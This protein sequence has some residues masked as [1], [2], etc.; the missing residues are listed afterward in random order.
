MKRR[1]ISLILALAMIILT[2]AGCAGGKTESTTPPES[3]APESVAPE[4]TT[5]PEAAKIDYPTQGITL[6]VPSKAGGAIDMVS[7]T[8]ATEMEKTLGQT[9]TV[10]NKEGGAA[11]A[12]AEYYATAKN[13]GYNLFI[14]DKGML[15]NHVAGTFT[16]SY[17]DFDPIAQVDESVQLI[18]CNSSL[19]YET[20][21]DVVEAANANPDT[22]T[23]GCTGTAGISFL[24]VFGLVNN[25]APL[26]IVP[27]SGGA[28]LKAAIS[29]GDVN[30]ASLKT[31]EVVALEEGGYLRVLACCGD[32]RVEAYPDVPTLKELGIDFAITQAT[33][34]WV[35]K[36]TDPEIISILEEAVKT[37][38]ESDTYQELCKTSLTDPKY[39]NSEELLEYSESEYAKIF[40]MLDAAGVAKK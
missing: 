40:D 8:L 37:A 23:I 32:E 13:D 12:I 2:F 11:G 9:I 38:V 15:S 22:I 21:E 3:K 26:K 39:L 7:R 1:S 28:E 30:L 18:V 20:L 10:V 16:V 29:G 24:S 6:T 27:Y 31:S 17:M 14:I 4:S 5:P 36:G 19:P 34:L 35:P 25:Q 33:S